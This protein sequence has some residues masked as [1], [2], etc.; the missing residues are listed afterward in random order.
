MRGMQYLEGG[1][2]PGVEA[3]VGCAGGVHA[4]HRWQPGVGAACVKAA[5]ELL[6]WR[7]QE[8]FSIVCT[9]ST[10][11]AV[12]PSTFEMICVDSRGLL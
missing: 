5:S 7:P 9:G 8:K 12:V 4:G 11:S 1:R 10:P 6:G 2:V 3:V